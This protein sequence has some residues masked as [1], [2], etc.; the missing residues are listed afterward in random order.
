MEYTVRELADMH[1]IY[2]RANGNGLLAKRLYVQ[3]YPNRRAPSHRIFARIHQRLRDTGSFEPRNH[4][5][6]RNLTVRT[7]DVEER[8]LVHV[9]E[10]PGISV[11]RIAARENVSRHSVWMTLHTQ[12]LYPYHIQRVQAL[13]P[14]D[15]PVRLMF[16][17]WLLRKLVQEPLFLENVLCTDEA[18]F[19]R[20]GIFNYHNTHHWSDENPHAVVES[21]HQIR[22]SVNVWAGILGDRLIG[23]FFLPLRLILH[24]SKSHLFLIIILNILG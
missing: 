19:T 3:K 13:A 22:F 18:G 4:D 11:R 5:R 8:I 12:L 2:G 20:N 9:E 14:A 23:P 17:R 6:G 21:R 24:L 1:F 7:P 16:C 10:D 15:Y